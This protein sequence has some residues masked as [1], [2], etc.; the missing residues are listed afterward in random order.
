MIIEKRETYSVIYYR[1]FKSHL[2]VRNSM[3]YLKNVYIL[4]LKIFKKIKIH[5][6]LS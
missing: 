3:W 4:Y 2:E 1:Y 5:N 6:Y